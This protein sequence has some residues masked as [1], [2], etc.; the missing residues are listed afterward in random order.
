VGALAQP[1]PG[2][3]AMSRTSTLDLGLAEIAARVRSGEVRATDLVD[4]AV[5]RIEALADRHNCLRRAYPDEAREQAAALDAAVERGEDPGRLAGV[6]IALKDN[7]DIAGLPAEA[8]TPFLAGTIAAQDAEVTRRLR[9]AGAILI[10]SAHMSEWAIGGTSQNVHYGFVLNAFDTARTSGGSSGGSGVVVGAGI[11]PAAL[12]TDTGGSVRLPAAFNGISGLR[13]THGR[14]SNRG[15]VP[16]AW[17]FDTIGPMARGADDVALL[18]QVMAGPDDGDPACAPRPADDYLT[19]L[20]DGVAGT[21]IGIPRDWVEEQCEAAAIAALDECAEVLRGLGATVVDVALPE[22]G[23]VYGWGG[24]LLMAEAAHVHAE[25]LATNPEGFA[26]D[27]RGRLEWGERMTGAEYAAARN[28]QRVFARAVERA[29]AGVDV[30]LCPTTP[31]PAPVLETLDPYE[32]ARTINVMTLPWVLSEQPALAVP[33]GTADGMPL[34]VQVIGRRWA[35]ADVLRVG[36][37]FQQ[38][39]DWHTLRPGA[40]AEGVA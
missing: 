21:R 11:L 24:T 12:G 18:L 32:V 34:S 29:M 4:E 23:A 22:A 6:P 3:G 25:R 20:G 36:H 14:V 13:P 27:V 15:C 7:I 5:A 1:G 38:A 30:L 39:T 35:E 19:H 33:A 2:G 16:V 17:S 37:A 8:S 40:L 10:A 9:A 26:P 31:Y 28:E